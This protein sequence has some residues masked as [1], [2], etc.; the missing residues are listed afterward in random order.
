M[1]E[2]LSL[3][4]DIFRNR[5]MIYKLAKNDFRKKFAGSYFGVIWAFVQPV[6]T[7]LVYW[8][9]FEVGFRSSDTSIPV[10]FLLYLVAGIVPWFF[11]Q[12]AW[13][14]GTNVL[15]EYSY[16]VKKIVFQIQVLPVVKMIS[17]LFVHL[18]FVCF[19]I[20]LYCFYGYYP[21]GY[22]VQLV[23]YS[24][25]LLLLTLGLSYATSAVT[26]LFRDL[27]Q[28]VAIVLQVGVWFTP[29]MWV[30]ENRL[31]NYP[32]LAKLLKLNPIY[33]VVAG[34]RDA[35]IYKNWFWE[36]PLWT[37]YFWCFTA[38]VLVMGLLIFRRLRVHFADVL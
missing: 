14:G 11:F 37:V 3:P 13:T 36:R 16:L 30:A 1:K 8:F 7:V 15:T 35:L 26:V 22:Y 24:C 25:G 6:V 29:I 21:D 27:S 34:Y 9:V 4:T 17:A 38:G 12:D 28:V 20:I 2:L 5:R 18:F 31:V 23:Y 19:I 10:P 32:L 33:Y